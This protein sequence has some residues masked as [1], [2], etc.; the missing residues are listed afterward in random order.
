VIAMQ[1]QKET[2]GAAGRSRASACGLAG[3]LE[4]P[5]DSEGRLVRQ[6]SHLKN[7]HPLSDATAIVIA[8]LMY[9]DGGRR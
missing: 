1:H 2:R 5:E 7:W 4:H 6:A 8:R 3:Q 9:S